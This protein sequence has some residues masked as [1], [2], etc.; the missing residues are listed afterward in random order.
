MADSAAAN[1]SYRLEAFGLPLV[2]STEDVPVPTGRAVLLR[3]LGCGVCHSD[4]HVADGYFDVGNGGRIDLAR[5]VA[6]PRI[7]GHEIV[8]EV[9]ALGPAAEGVAL[10]DRRVVFPWIG[11]GTCAACTGGDEHLCGAPRALGV[12]RDGGF[13]HHVLVEDA[14]YL[15][16]FAPLPQTQ[17]CTLA[18]SGLTAFSAL[19]KA[20]PFANG[21]TALVI[22]AGGVGL[23]AIRMAQHVLGTAPIVAEPDRAKWPLA[24]E[25]GAAAAIDPREPGAARELVKATRGGVAA[26][27]DFVG[28]GESFAFGFSA[29]AKG[30]RMVAVGLMGGSAQFSPALLPLKSATICGSYVGSLSEMADLMRLARS[31]VLPALPVIARRLADVND[32]LDDLRAARVHGRIVVTP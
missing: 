21:A 29:L 22:G 16:D 2:A 18:C 5:S 31:G 4:L 14:R 30:G 15:F 19:R 20:A 12:N 13:A 10:G 11:C 7:L 23:S 3:A 32:A 25:A 6:L 27:F 24:I 17:A 1:R 9:V 8:G 26:A 28:S